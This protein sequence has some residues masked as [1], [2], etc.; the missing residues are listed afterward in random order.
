MAGPL[1]TVRRVRQ[2]AE[3]AARRIQRALP[4][5]DHAVVAV[6]GLELEVDPRTEIGYAL[7]CGQRFEARERDVAAALYLERRG[8]AI[9]DVGAHIGI[10]A[11]AWARS[12]PD[13]TVVAC[14]ASPATAA[15][16]EANAKRN[17]LAVTVVAAAVGDHDGWAELHV[18]TDDAYTSLSDTQR[19]PIRERVRV[20]LTTLDA[21]APG[22][23][24]LIKI[25]VEGHEAAVL[26]GAR[27]TIARD[28]P[29]LFVEIYAGIASNP[30]PEATIA[31]ICG[32]GYAAWVL[33][34]HGLERYVRHDDRRYN[35]F[36]IPS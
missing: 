7:W 12:F 6:D 32:L 25:D 16:L 14:E 22:R 3:R 24:G 36:F 13:A 33:A 21:I 18:A 1:S 34:E 29:V 5:P 8:G 26:A 15:R 9:I 4:R 2:L 27:A 10:H 31:T 23:V 20:P 30:D 11:L 28:H 17:H 35:Y 19:K